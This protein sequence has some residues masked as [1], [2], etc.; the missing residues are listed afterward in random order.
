MIITENSQLPGNMS[1]DEY[2]QARKIIAKKIEE[3]HSGFNEPFDIDVCCLF[4]YISGEGKT[5]SAYK[6]FLQWLTLFMLK[7]KRAKALN[8]KFGSKGPTYFERLIE[9]FMGM[10]ENGQ[11]QLHDWLTWK[12]FKNYTYE[13]SHERVRALWNEFVN[14]GLK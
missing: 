3:K 12:D 11:E 10:E 13:T 5:P 1:E 9:F 2:I 4:Q 6:E 8:K 14:P 7:P